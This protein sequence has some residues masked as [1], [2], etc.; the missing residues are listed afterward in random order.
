M[1]VCITEK[2][3]VGADIAKILGATTRRDGYFEGAGYCVTWTF[4]HLC[5]L[6]EPAD[7][8][9]AWRRWSLSQLPMI[10]QHF[11]KNPPASRAHR[12]GDTRGI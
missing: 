3:S 9:P 7:Y 10:P 11:T 6:K 5:T 12:R 1:I 8:D 2:P 4:G